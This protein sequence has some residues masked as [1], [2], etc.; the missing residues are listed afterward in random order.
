MATVS[1]GQVRHS[2]AD[3]AGAL[4]DVPKD[5]DEYTLDV[6]EGLT[7]EVDGEVHVGPVLL[8]RT[9][10][11]SKAKVKKV[12]GEGELVGHYHKVR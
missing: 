12:D 11:A 3:K 5:A 8:I 2:L 4:K 6:P 10:D 1:L 7:V 9:G